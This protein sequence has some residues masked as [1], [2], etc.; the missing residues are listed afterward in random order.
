M[1]VIVSTKETQ[2]QRK[3]D[4]CWVPE[5]EPV[6]FSMECDG[7]DVDGSCGCRRAL[8]G[9]RSDRAT[10]TMKVV[11]IDITRDEFRAAIRDSLV[12]SGWI[13]KDEADAPEHAK[14][15]DGD[16]DELLRLAA[17]FDAGDVIEKRGEAINV[18]KSGVE[19]LSQDTLFPPEEPKEE[20]G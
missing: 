3:N 14:W 9:M 5:G 13:K 16:T 19:P 4:F 20:V 2:G 1:K 17:C 10:T 8:G 11:E 12:G 7:E 15:I 6:T 18:R